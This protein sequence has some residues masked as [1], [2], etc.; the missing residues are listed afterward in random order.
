M[1]KYKSLAINKAKVFFLR[2]KHLKNVFLNHYSYYFDTSTMRYILLALLIFIWNIVVSQTE[3]NLALEYY[4]NGDYAK[5]AELYEDLFKTSGT[6]THLNYLIKCYKQLNDYKKAEKTLTKA[7][8][9][10]PYQLSYLVDIGLLYKEQ[11]NEKKA[12]SYFNKAINDLSNDANQAIELANAFKN[13]RELSYA[14]KVY[15]KARKISKNG[16]GYNIEL[17]DIYFYQRNFEGMINELINL[18]DIDDAYLE[19]VQRRLQSALYNDIDNSLTTILK[20][21]LIR[22]LQKTPNSEGYNE[23]MIWLNIQQKEFGQALILAKALDKRGGEEGKRIS[24]LAEMA[25]KNEDYDIAIDA[26]KYIISKGKDLPYYISAKS[27][28]LNA[29]YKKITISTQTSQQELQELVKLYESTIEEFGINGSSASLIKDLAHIKAFYMDKID[30]AI[31]LLENVIAKPRMSKNKLAECRTEMGDILVLKGDLWDADLIFA[32]VE[33]DNEHNPNGFEAKLKRA[34][35]QYYA[36]NFTYA[37]THLDILKASTSKLIANDAFDL[38]RLINDNTAMDT[39]F[40]GM[41]LFSEA[42]LLLYQRKDSLAFLLF[43]SIQNSLPGH[44]LQDDIYFKK[45][46]YYYNRGEYKEAQKMFDAIKSRYPEDIYADNALYYLGLIYENHLQMPE[47]AKECFKTLLT[48]YGDSI[49]IVEARKHFR[50]LRG[51]VLEQ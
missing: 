25:F 29:L 27:D 6:Q 2:F 21:S 1:L 7:F 11:D 48:Q 10:F 45:G 37:Q 35:I 3:N 40:V 30:D 43:D 34:K 20:E 26:N 5:A 4:Q 49:Y 22:K 39:S 41:L 46:E 15:L 47:K 50:Q 9:E 17:A 8:K 32:R 12:E 24:E 14:E 23:M 13:N 16:Y 42:D 44:S 18:I 19:T 28:L 33:K 38:A 31:I 51:D 36:G